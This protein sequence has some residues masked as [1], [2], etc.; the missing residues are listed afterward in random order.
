MSFYV[1]LGLTSSLWLLWQPLISGS[2]SRMPDPIES[3]AIWSVVTGLLFMIRSP[4]VAYNEA[5]VALI[6]EPGSFP[7]LKKFSWIASL[8]TTAIAAIF[9]LTP[10]SRLWFT[11]GANLKPGDVDIARLT[12]VL[13]LPL[14]VLSVYVSFFQGIIVNREKT[15][16]VAE[17]VVLFLITLTAILL[18]GV[19]TDFAKGVYIASGA[20]SAAH[21]AQALW[22]LVRSRKQRHN[23]I[24]N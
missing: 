2:V 12:L 19:V 4:G 9:I 11:S 7:K 17:A 8:I 23:L 10:L 16:P 24:N 14:G 20:F 22:L 13:G 5:V 1:P 21:L 18:T 3:L 15:G 6:E